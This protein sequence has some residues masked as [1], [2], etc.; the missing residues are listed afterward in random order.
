MFLQTVSP[1][2]DL[3]AVALI[4]TAFWAAWTDWT[5]WRIPNRLVV[6]SSVAALMI[7]VFSTSG[8]GLLH[9]L[10]GGMVGM[11]LLLPLY[12][13]RGMAAGDVKLVGAIG[14]H[15]GAIAITQIIFIS[16]LIA[17]L[18]SIAKLVARTETAR[19]CGVW[20]R[21]V[22]R[23]PVATGV[24]EERMSEPLLRS[25]SRGSIP[26]GVVIAIASTTICVLGWI[27]PSST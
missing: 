18:W 13:L 3:N 15:A 12:L 5:S 24:G 23:L 20:L 9:T 19:Y 10:I 6:A 11:A 2:S 22:T 4:I 17:G 26:Y 21:S 14:L 25:S 8:T 16:A 7:G 1:I 27:Q